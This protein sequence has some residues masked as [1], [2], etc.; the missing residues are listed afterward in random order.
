MLCFVFFLYKNIQT[1]YTIFRGLVFIFVHLR[2]LPVRFSVGLFCV[3]VRIF[4][5]RF[6]LYAVVNMSP[7]FQSCV[8]HRLFVVIV[9]LMFFVIFKQANKLTDRIKC[10]YFKLR[11]VLLAV[12]LLLYCNIYC[13]NSA[14]LSYD[15]FWF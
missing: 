13:F 12:S 11:Y 15:F 2:R 9:S 8:Q 10:Q 14:S 1:F 6:C 4:A 5:N 7:V 3:C